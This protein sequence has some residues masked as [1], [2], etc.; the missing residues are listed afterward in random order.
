MVSG[1]RSLSC[2]RHISMRSFSPEHVPRTGTF[3]WVMTTEVSLPLM[4]T[5]VIPAEEMALKAYSV[6]L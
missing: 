3:R 2:N 4:A 5:A 1:S 6:E